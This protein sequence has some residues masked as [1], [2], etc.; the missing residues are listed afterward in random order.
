MDLLKLLK[1]N[2]KNICI[3]CVILAAVAVVAGIMLYR[4]REN[5]MSSATQ[6]RDMIREKLTPNSSETTESG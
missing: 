2:S 6:L 3:M 5:F 1:K 4:Q